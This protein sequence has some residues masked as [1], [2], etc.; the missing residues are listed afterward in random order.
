MSEWEQRDQDKLLQ[1]LRQDY[2][3]FRFHPHV[4]Y[5]LYSY[6]S[7]LNAF[8][9]LEQKGRPDALPPASPETE[10]NTELL[11]SIAKDEAGRELLTSIVASAAT[12]HFGLK[13]LGDRLLQQRGYHTTDLDDR[14]LFNV[15]LLYFA[16]GLT[17]GR[18]NSP[19]PIDLLVPNDTAANRILRAVGPNSLQDREYAS[20]LL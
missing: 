12:G 16:G 1:R 4:E 3:G 5:T 15:A 18:S 17:F 8:S 11:K 19:L 2:N 13:G 20:H 14:T 7:I 9:I 10:I 6:T